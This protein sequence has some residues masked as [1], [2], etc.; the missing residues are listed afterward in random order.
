MRLKLNGIFLLLDE[1][2][3]PSAPS[4]KLNLPRTQNQPISN[5]TNSA[6]YYNSGSAFTEPPQSPRPN[7]PQNLYSTTPRSRDRHQ[8]QAYQNYLNLKSNS[9]STKQSQDHNN[10]YSNASNYNNDQQI[11]YSSYHQQQ[12]QSFQPRPP[13]N[14]HVYYTPNKPQAQQENVQERKV[15][16]GM[17]SYNNNRPF[18]GRRKSNASSMPFSLDRSVAYDPYRNSQFPSSY[19]GDPNDGGMDGYGNSGNYNPASLRSPNR[20]AKIDHPYDEKLT[21]EP[22]NLFAQN[23]TVP[24]LEDIQQGA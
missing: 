15:S 1:N 11:Q 13:T 22:P 18:D 9:N 20:S 19:G 17:N 24:K 3:N 4:Y 14:E 21:V 23:L 6:N 16:G 2:H 12:Q 7:F 10:N 5:N 8:S